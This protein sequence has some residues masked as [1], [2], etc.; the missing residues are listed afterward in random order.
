[1]VSARPAAFSRSM[2]MMRSGLLLP[3]TRDRPRQH[4]GVVI[5]H[6]CDHPH[7]DAV[8]VLMEQGKQA[9]PMVD[10]RA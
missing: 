2:A 9:L 5:G 1:M 3:L 10:C 4:D 6:A 7:M 8:R